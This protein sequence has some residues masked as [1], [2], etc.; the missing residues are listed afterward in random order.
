M[1]MLYISRA[2]KIFLGFALAAA[3]LA[4]SCYRGA[5]TPSSVHAP[6]NGALGWYPRYAVVQES[7]LRVFAQQREDAA[8][9]S[10]MRRGDIAEILEISGADEDGYIWYR[11]ALIA[12]DASKTA[13]EASKNSDASGSASAPK[14]T[15]AKGW[16][17]SRGAVRVQSMEQARFLSKT[18]APPPNQ[19]TGLRTSAAARDAQKTEN[20]R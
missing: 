7:Y 5:Q 6:E 19:D 11:V 20:G 14:S 12:P 13:P 8:V 16:I 1:M 2:R 15:S 17:L 18:F 4:A 9:Q 3:L 10:F